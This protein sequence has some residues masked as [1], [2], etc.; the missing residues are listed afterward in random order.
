MKSLNTLFS[1]QI[2][3]QKVWPMM[4][5]CWMPDYMTTHVNASLSVIITI[6]SWCFN[7]K[8]KIKKHFVAENC[9]ETK[10]NCVYWLNYE[11]LFKLYINGKLIIIQ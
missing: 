3:F 10:A 8:K 2:H 1:T 11:A 6:L 4:G 5:F 9:K 7:N